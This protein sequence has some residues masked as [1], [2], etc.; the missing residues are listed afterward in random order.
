MVDKQE[1]RIK[2]VSVFA[3]RCYSIWR[4]AFY[5]LKITST[6]AIIGREK[7]TAAKFPRD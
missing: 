1:V 2:M 3:F 6:V 5:R 4:Y 7:A